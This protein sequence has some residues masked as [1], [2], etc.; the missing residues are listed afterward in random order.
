[1]IAKAKANLANIPK[2]KMWDCPPEDSNLVW[3][4]GDRIAAFHTTTPEAWPKIQ[5]EGFKEGISR[6][7]FDGREMP[8][9]VWVNNT[10]FLPYSI[11]WFHP[12]FDDEG[13]M[14]I[15]AVTIPKQDIFHYEVTWPSMQWVVSSDDIEIIGLLEPEEFFYW[16]TEPNLADHIETTLKQKLAPTDGYLQKLA[17]VLDA[18]NEEASA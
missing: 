16:R 9:G 3:V 8:K 1:M 14:V 11:D 6:V 7:G 4:A 13:D 15:I 5:A 17:D 10:P 18:A 2:D 12:A